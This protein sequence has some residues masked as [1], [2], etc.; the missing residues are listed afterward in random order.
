MR[1][2]KRYKF[3]LEDE[4]RLEK[5][6][7]HSFSPLSLAMAGVGGMLILMSLGAL[8]VGLTPL[9]E[10]MP[11]NLSYSRRAE[12]E[13]AMLRLD[14]LNEVYIRNEVFL[15]NVNRV[16]D[17]ERQPADSSEIAVGKMTPTADSLI[18]RSAEE[19]RFAQM[20]QNREKFNISMIA[21]M[22]ADG[23]LM[24]PVSDEGIIAS[25]SRDDYEVRVVLPNHA[26]VMAIADGV[27][28]GGYYDTVRK[29]YVL[30]TQHDNGFVSRI[31]GLG[32][33]LVAES[34]L[35]TGGEIIA[36]PAIP[37]NGNPTTLKVSLWHNGTPVKPY[38]YVAGHRYRV[39]P[40]GEG[41][42]QIKSLS[43]KI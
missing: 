1:P 41:G 35:V 38:E 21:S 30:L 20:M 29:S 32:T 15:A 42:G 43:D 26:S 23:M 9:R 17:T 3:T 18:K 31:S 12:T 33:L 36:R 4:S 19:T 37:R 34:D 25:D 39:S 14:S 24:Y 28:I 7:S 6:A 16:L 10:L 8:I 11:G 5:I 13:N 40:G 2:S 22:A 27:I